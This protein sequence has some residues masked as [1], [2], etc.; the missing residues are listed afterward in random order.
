MKLIELAD[1]IEEEATDVVIAGLINQIALPYQEGFYT[2]LY[3][4][5]VESFVT[6]STGD[7][8]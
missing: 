4:H 1:H 8:F 7:S 6:S 5:K 2:A 3:Q